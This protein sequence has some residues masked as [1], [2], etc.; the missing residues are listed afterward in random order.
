MMHL[1]A[2]LEHDSDRRP[3]RRLDRRQLVL[4][5]VDEFRDLRD[6][7]ER[8]RRPKEL[9]IDSAR[10]FGAVST[11]RRF[12]SRIRVLDRLSQGRLRTQAMQSG[13]HRIPRVVL[14][15]EYLP[16]LS[17]FGHEKSKIVFCGGCTK[18][19]FRKRLQGKTRQNLE[20]NESQISWPQI[21]SIE[22]LLE[23]LR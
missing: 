16:Y 7:L 13:P 19:P 23:R 12:R 17:D 20:A 1:N 5:D 9:E 10:R 14:E 4:R 15:T 6:A 11:R 8:H 18:N 2:Y 22:T 3:R 21:L